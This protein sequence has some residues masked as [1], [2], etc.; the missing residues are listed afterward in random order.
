MGQ[1]IGSRQRSSKRPAQA[2][3]EG[4]DSLDESGWFDSASCALVEAE[5]SD[6]G[7][8]KG[9]PPNP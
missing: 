4:S 8:R 3:S 9:H 1:G 7:G 2:E 5:R 6:S